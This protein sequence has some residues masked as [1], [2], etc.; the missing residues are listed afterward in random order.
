MSDVNPTKLPLYVEISIKLLSEVAGTKS[1]T[2]FIGILP[3]KNKGS[4]EAVQGGRAAADSLWVQV[5]PRSR[6]DGEHTR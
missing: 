2:G 3:Y 1:S 4:V 5:I 6:N